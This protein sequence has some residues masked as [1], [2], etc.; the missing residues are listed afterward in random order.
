MADELEVAKTGQLEAEAAVQTKDADLAKHQA[1][2]EQLEKSRGELAVSLEL[3]QRLRQERDEEMRKMLVLTSQCADL[4]KT[5]QV[6]IDMLQTHQVEQTRL[7]GEQLQSSHLQMES[8]IQQLVDAI[9]Q[10]YVEIAT[11]IR[12]VS[13]IM[14]RM[15]CFSSPILIATVLINVH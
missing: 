12:A 8:A 6:E 2:S 4:E 5:H 13:L 3:V 9:G 14:C 11:V 7:Y 1:G 15:Y 10:K